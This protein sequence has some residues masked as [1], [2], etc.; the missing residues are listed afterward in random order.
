M[1]PSPKSQSKDSKQAMEAFDAAKEQAVPEADH[2]DHAHSPA[3]HLGTEGHVHTEPEGKGKQGREPG[4]LRA[5]PQDPQ[6]NGKTN[7][8]Q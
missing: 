1:P 8:R 3:A 2:G 5:P 4:T 7:H 6:R